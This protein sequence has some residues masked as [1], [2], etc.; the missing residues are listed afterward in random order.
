MTPRLRVIAPPPPR[1]GRVLAW[2]RDAHERDRALFTGARRQREIRQ[3]LAARRDDDD[4]DA[5]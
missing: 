4:G 5:A 3:A 2:R 1:P